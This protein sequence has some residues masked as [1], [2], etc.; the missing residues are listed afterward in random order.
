MS[1][2]SM[3]CCSTCEPFLSRGVEGDKRGQKPSG[4]GEAACRPI[5]ASLKPRC[6]S[7]LLLRNIIT[8]T[9]WH[10]ASHG[11]MGPG[12]RPLVA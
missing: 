3:L 12:S 4:L 10:R 9:F 11:P 8:A 2:A 1:R 6:S 5:A 7:Y